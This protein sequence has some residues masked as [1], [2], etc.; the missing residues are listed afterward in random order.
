MTVPVLILALLLLS[1]AASL[2]LAR[3]RPRLAYN[4]ALTGGLLAL[5]LW[6]VLWF[7]LPFSTA[8][9]DGAPALIIDSA[10][11]QISLLLLI[12]L[13][14]VLMAGLGRNNSSSGMVAGVMLLLVCAGLGSLWA[15]SLMLLLPAWALLGVIWTLAL[16]SAIKTTLWKLLSTLALAWTGVFFIAMGAANL[17]QVG[18][19]LLQAGTQWTDAA[20]IWTTLGALWPLLALPF[21]ATQGPAKHAASE[22]TITLYAVPAAAGGLLLFRLVEISAPGRVFPLLLIFP[23]LILCLWALNRAWVDM[24]L[25]GEQA[26]ALW[27]ALAALVVLAATGAV[28]LPMLWVLM[29]AGGVFLLTPMIGAGGSSTNPRLERATF[30]FGPAIALAAMAGLPLTAGF[31]ALSALYDAWIADGFWPLVPVTMLLLMPLIAAGL[32]SVWS[33]RAT[34]EGPDA[35]VNG[36]RS[37]LLS[38]L[39]LAVPAIFLLTP[40]GLTT[41][42]LWSWSA[43]LLGIGGGLALFRYQPRARQA[44]AAALAALAR[45]SLPR[46]PGDLLRRGF[47]QGA[48]WLQQAA[49]ILEGEWGLLWL[50]LFF[51]LLLLLR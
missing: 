15:G 13:I 24:Q 10:A 51:A 44:H 5:L 18:P 11:W 21:L 36:T 33:G 23:A 50:L 12:L 9:A 2:L 31:A 35:A 32:S 30:L 4:A 43:I 3:Y 20:L 27:F 25:P 37:P 49:A 28:V 38:R 17:A 26:R 40:A 1:S 39:A 46:W 6:L 8:S 45:R 22:V 48:L 34:P 14:S 29:L 16:S 19:G 7:Q 42:G 47:S 41:A